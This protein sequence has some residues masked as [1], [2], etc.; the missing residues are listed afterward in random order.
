MSFLNLAKSRFSLR[1]YTTQPVSDDDLKN[2]LEAGRVAPSAVNYQPWKF[3]VIRE[4]ETLEMVHTLYHREWFKQAPVVIIILADHEQSWIRSDGKDHADIDIAIAA[5]HMTLA[6]TDLGLGTCWVCNFD[7]QK[8]IE[9]FK[10]PE[11]LE[12]LV[13][14]PL[15]HP[16]Q[17]TDVNRHKT[18][19]KPFDQIVEWR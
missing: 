5:D 1:K 3:L 14:L 15:G 9:A 8:T 13:F 4:K 7:K 2:I 18:K 19:R 12:P 11:N 10:L 6:A 16:D 17:E